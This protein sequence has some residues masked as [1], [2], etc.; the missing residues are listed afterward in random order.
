MVHDFMGLSL[1]PVDKA[2]EIY[3]KLDEDEEEKLSEVVKFHSYI[4]LL[5]NDRH[6]N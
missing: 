4:T 2:S 3:S 6:S 5:F 1:F